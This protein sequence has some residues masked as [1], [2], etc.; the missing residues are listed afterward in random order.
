MRNELG[1][2]TGF[3]HWGT[4]QGLLNN[5]IMA[6]EED[7][8][9][10]LWLST[11]QGL[12]RFNP[13][14]HQTINFVTESGLPVS[15][16]NTNASGA[17]EAYIYFGS[18]DG[19][20]SFKK[21]SL[22]EERSP[23]PVRITQMQSMT[24]DGQISNISGY[25][26]NLPAKIPYGEV[27]TLRFATL[28]YSGASHDYAYR[29]GAEDNWVSLGS[30]RQII[31]PGL[32]PGKYQVQARGRDVFGLWGES[33]LLYFEIVPPF[34]LTAWFRMLLVLAILLAGYLLHLGR[35]NRIQRHAREIQRLSEKRETAL[36]QALGSEAELA[37]L[38]P[39]Q[40][41]ILQLIAEGYS[42]REIAGLLDVSIKTV[43]AHRANLMERLG[44]HD[45]PGL[46]R[47]AIRSRLVS[48]H[49]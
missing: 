35:A 2:V 26:A 5:G 39:R 1:E 13:L 18:A 30:Q 21:G 33:E 7:M 19:L 40:K 8:D 4:D 10:S 24:R 29:L 9:E 43:E 11:R 20:L 14:T 25:S 16:Y 34:W 22:L 47:L 38:T 46:V 37:V 45:V 49:E 32:Q 12:S 6:I 31:I 27:I 23:A 41:E 15:H 44:I 28:D 3:T 48:P 17:D 36:E 42:S